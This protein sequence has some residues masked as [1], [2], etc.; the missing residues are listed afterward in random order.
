M[1]ALQR[2][3]DY[4]CGLEVELCKPIQ[5]GGACFL[6]NTVR[7]HASFAMNAYYQ[8][9][10]KNDYDCDF[11]QTAA[12]SNVDPSMFIFFLHF[13]S[14]HSSQLLFHRE[15]LFEEFEFLV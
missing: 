11:K 7:A 13:L 8:G 9:T 5:E 1:E 3:I 2:N 6:P 15:K 4:V 10:E 14:P 12:V